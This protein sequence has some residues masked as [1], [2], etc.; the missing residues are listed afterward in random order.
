M[1]AVIDRAFCLKHP[2]RI[3]RLFGLDIYLGM[4]FDRRKTLLQRVTEKYQ[5][6]AIPMPGPVGNAYKLSA[7]FELRVARIYA[8][9]ADRFR[10]VPEASSLFRDL[11]EEEQ[12]HARIML[13][14]L[15][16]V[17]AAP[18]LQFVPSIRD[19]QIREDL[20]KLREVERQV[21][22]MTLDEALTI[23]G[24]LERGE[25]NVIFGRLLEQ[26]DR[27]Q[28]TLF[29]EHL[30]GAQG[31]GESVPRRIAELKQQREARASSRAA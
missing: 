22:S 23:T 7:L 19:P 1:Q 18:S 21:P 31:H 14:C 15:F 11:S 10:D 29:A 24:E 6:G 8:A 5:A 26:V 30:A 3:I 17:T 13:T 27:S 16:Q 28:L 20:A 25:V 4:L 9:M 12:E 2:A